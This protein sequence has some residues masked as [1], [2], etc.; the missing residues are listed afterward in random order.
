MRDGAVLRH[1]ETSAGMFGCAESHRLLHARVVV[2]RPVEQNHLAGGGKVRHVALEIPL[3]FLAIGR[4]FQRHHPRAARIE[5]LGC[6]LS[7]SICRRRFTRWY[8]ARGIH[9]T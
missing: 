4:L 1:A 8:S 2:P 3:R 5:M 7:S 6:S 9:S